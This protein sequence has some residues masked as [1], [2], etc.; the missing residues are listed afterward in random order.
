MNASTLQLDL[1][2]LLGLAVIMLLTAWLLARFPIQSWTERRLAWLFPTDMVVSWETMGQSHPYR[3][4]LV[5][6]FILMGTFAILLDLGLTLSPSLRYACGVGIAIVGLY[7]VRAA[8]TRRAALQ[9]AGAD[10]SFAK[11][12]SPRNP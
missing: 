1:L 11:N 12:R 10:L 4:L 6:F 5:A 9:G 3:Y 2:V 8:A 7:S